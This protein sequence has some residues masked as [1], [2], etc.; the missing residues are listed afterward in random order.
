MDFEGPFKIKEVVLKTFSMGHQMS[1]PGASIDKYLFKIFQNIET[2]ALSR[3][4]TY[5]SIENSCRNVLYV[6][7]SCVCFRW[8]W[9]LPSVHEWIKPRLVLLEAKR[10]PEGKRKVEFTYS[11]RYT[12]ADKADRRRL[13]QIY[14]QM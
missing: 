1:K 12:V 3:S 9:E 6:R 14:L 13:N 8:S 2:V 4:V 11:R 10:G 7:C 5:T